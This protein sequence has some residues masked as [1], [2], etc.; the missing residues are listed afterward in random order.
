MKIESL[1]VTMMPFGLVFE[2]ILLLSNRVFCYKY[3]LSLKVVIHT[4]SLIVKLPI[5]SNNTVL[6]RSLFCSLVQ[7]KMFQRLIHCTNGS[8]LR[9]ICVFV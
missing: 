9:G 5:L 7:S 6:C 3:S 4:V 8:F 1:P 2:Q